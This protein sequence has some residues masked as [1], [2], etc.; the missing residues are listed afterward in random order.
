MKC[1]FCLD[2]S[3]V[4]VSRN[5]MRF[6]LIETWHAFSLLWQALY[7]KHINI[8]TAQQNKMRKAVLFYF[9]KGAWYMLIMNKFI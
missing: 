5:Q 1:K 7:N 3:W 2:V 8:Y 4:S 9:E 6:H